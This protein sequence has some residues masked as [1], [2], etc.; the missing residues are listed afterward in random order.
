MAEN[1]S[2]LKG[3]IYRPISNWG[4]SCCIAGVVAAVQLLY[5]PCF[6]F[7]EDPFSLKRFYNLLMVIFATLKVLERLVIVPLSFSNA[8]TISCRFAFVNLIGSS[9][10]NTTLIMFL[11]KICI[12]IV[13]EEFLRLILQFKEFLFIIDHA[14]FE[15]RKEVK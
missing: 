6:F 15:F 5:P 11:L 4:R 13:I 14:K 10:L 12:Q 2:L 1:F 9:L 7:S 8:L 3:H